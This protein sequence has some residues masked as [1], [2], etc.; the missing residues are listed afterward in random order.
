[1][2]TLIER[3]KNSWLSLTMWFNASLATIWLFLPELTSTLPVLQDYLDGDYYKKLMLL[4][5]IGNMIL[6]VK[7]TQD[8]ANKGK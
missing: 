2:K 3:L 1:M 8:L 5:I 6:R 7:T 4:A